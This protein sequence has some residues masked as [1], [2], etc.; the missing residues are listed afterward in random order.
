MH[1]RGVGA[2]AIA[3]KKLAEAS[4]SSLLDICIFCQVEWALMSLLLL[5]IYSGQVQR[6]RNGDRGG[7]DRPGDWFSNAGGK[8]RP[9]MKL[10][11]T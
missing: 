11:F 5:C 4:I 8:K 6:K 10:E 3:K 1:R 9:K 7:S 2:G